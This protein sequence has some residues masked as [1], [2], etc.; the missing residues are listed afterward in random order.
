[1]MYKKLCILV[2]VLGLTGNALGDL[3]GHWA[4][5]GNA[6]DSSVNGNNGTI[7][8]SVS[9]TT[10]RDSN[11]SSA[12]L[13]GGGASDLINLGNPAEFQ[14]TGEM[15]LMAWVNLNSSSTRNGRVISKMAG[16]G[17]R[18]WTLNIENS[19]LGITKPG[20]FYVSS[21]GS[22][23]IEVHDDTSLPQN[24]WVHLAGVYQPGSY[25][26]LYLNG[27]LAGEKTS[28]V[29]VSQFSNNGKNVLIGNRVDAGDC[30]WVGSLDEVRIYNEA[31]SEAE[32]EAIMDDSPDPPG[33]ASVP[34]PANGIS[35]VA[36]NADLYWT[37]GSGA[38]SHDVYFGTTSPGTFQGDQ[39]PTTFDTGT[40]IA[41]TIYYWRI[42]EKNDNGTTTGTV[43]NFTT[44]SGE[45]FIISNLSPTNYETVYD[46]LNV[47]QL[48]YVDRTAEYATV[49]SSY[50]G[51]TYIKTGNDDKHSTDS[52]FMSFDINHEASVYVA[53]DDRLASKPTWLTS[54]FTDTGDDLVD[55]GE[56]V[57]L[58]LYKKDFA[59]GTVTLGGN[60]GGG[61]PNCSMYTVVVIPIATAPPGQAGNPNP[62]SGMFGVARNA[63]LSWTTGSGATSHDV[64]FGTTSPGTFQGNQ[65][66]ATY[67]PGTMD[68]NTAYYWRIDEKNA[69]GTTTGSVWSFTTGNSITGPVNIMPLGDSITQGYTT[70]DNYRHH[71]WDK[72]QSDGYSNL[73]FVGSHDVLAWDTFDSLV[74]DK[75][76]E[77]HYGWHTDE[78]RD[79]GGI[80]EGGSGNLNSWLTGL[81]ATDEV[82]DI[83]L[84]HLGTNDVIH[85]PAGYDQNTT[86]DEMEDVIDILRSYN[87]DVT[88]LLAK[89]IPHKN[90]SAP[91][92][93]SL[94]ALIPGLDSYETATSEV[95]I[96]D[97][98]SGFSTSWLA[99]NY[100][101][102]TTGA[103]EMSDRWY[104]ALLPV[105]NRACEP[106]P[107]NETTSIPYNDA[108]LS[109]SPGIKAVSHNV[110][111]GT[112]ES[113]VESAGTGLAGDITSNG[114]VNYFDLKVL[115]RQ[116]LAAPGNPSADL[117]D[118]SA[119]NF[120][121]YV[122]FANDWMQNGSSSPLFMGN[123]SGTTFD[124]CTLEPDV[125]Y[126]W[127]IDE[128]NNSEPTSPWKG[129]VWSFT[130]YDPSTLP[131]VIVSTDIGGNDPDDDQSMV[132][133][134]VYADMFD[135]EGLISSP[136]YAGR[137]S[138][139]LEVI[140][141]YVTDYNNLNSHSDF[142]TPQ[143]LRDVTKQGATG[144][145]PS[146]GYSSATE[147][148]NWIISRA[149]VADPRP[150]W[151]LVWGSI[152]DVA[153]AVH[154]D[155][156]IKSKIRVYS[157]GSW[158][159]DQCPYSRDYLYNNHSDMWW[160]ENDS[161]FRGMY[162]GGYQSGDYGNST[163]VSAH[164]RYHG[165]LGDYYYS[166]KPDIKMGDTPSVLY[167]LNGNP[168]T[169][170]TSHWG[171]MFRLESVHTP[172]I[173]TDRLEPEYA[174]G[175]YDGAKT[176]N[177]HRVDY[178][179]DWEIRMDW[180][181]AP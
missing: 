91:S 79:G 85:N 142:P 177:V 99:D 9:A 30:G 75:D 28:G 54:D 153:Q 90:G 47:G 179:D 121:D 46:A 164:V 127:R 165:A 174:E 68:A 5:D 24:Q 19:W 41:S 32:I 48:L 138:D 4:L 63:D 102:N 168:D 35:G 122:I 154:D 104:D 132:H 56:S 58:S 125:N 145:A 77:G 2:L 118:D 123:Q 170:T 3:V 93:D 176:V 155:P 134:F 45:S 143:S 38:T 51:K 72:L 52:S 158:N 26:R 33:Q 180:A 95:I 112:D 141:E 163:F 103:T 149:N 73:N 159:T 6:L 114:P 106:D 161:T 175:S 150:L 53:H 171:G 137:K 13:F 49:P 37:A 27:D 88:I 23:V 162:T 84:M 64:Y 34:N 7:S 172:P 97:H 130:T 15:T 67:D 81:Q 124:P 107:E 43:W 105:L 166:M 60:E 11:P 61:Q 148:S 169:P 131:R 136:P 66:S 25:M 40:M 144:T 92:V 44:G 100:H 74:F 17:S 59:S 135:T 152:T 86:I 156:G 70:Y 98:H 108:E 181:D 80:S 101:P 16:P 42:D 140:D 89:I 83:V 29:P 139:I 94:N 1:M 57:V 21:N 76:H 78:I 160:I 129:R 113:A 87:Q 146:A 14:L 147:G 120:D 117:D 109:W 69:Y 31:L 55:D 110:Y 157:I 128:R 119:V 12:M 71:L 50:Q 18:S 116:W 36:L 65:S 173:W 178:L 96:V 10:D 133:Y 22:D 82:P 115:G 8:G 111:F 151:I 126:Y 20:I 167:L 62:S 39:T